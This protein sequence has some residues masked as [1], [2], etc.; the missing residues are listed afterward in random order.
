MY[1]S[2]A[3]FILNTRLLLDEI[4]IEQR[5]LA[6]ETDERNHIERSMLAE[7][8]R[9]QLQVEQAKHDAEMAAQIGDTLH[10]EVS[11]TN[12]ANSDF[13]HCKRIS[14]V[15]YYMPRILK[16]NFSHSCEILQNE[17]KTSRKFP[18]SHY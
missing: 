13:F 12:L 3:Y 9:L 17:S 15:A 14:V 11:F 5:I 4:K 7:V 6:R 2:S 8:D 10:K 16:R 18:S 1:I